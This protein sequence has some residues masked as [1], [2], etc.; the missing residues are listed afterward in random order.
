MATATQA[1]IAT[2]EDR[3]QSLKSAAKHA[4]EKAGQAAQQAQRKVVVAATGFGLGKLRARSDTAHAE[5]FSIMDMDAETSIAI[6]ATG[7]EL[8]IDDPDIKS[9]AGAVS[10]AS[11]AVA[12]YKLGQ[13]P[14]TSR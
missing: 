6:L 11:I 3:M 10:D 5:A 12:A 14:T 4:R 13:R 9:M 8:F 2:L 1:E 7:A